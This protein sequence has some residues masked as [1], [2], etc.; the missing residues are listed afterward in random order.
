MAASPEEFLNLSQRLYSSWPVVFTQIPL[1]HRFLWLDLANPDMIM[2]LLTGASMWVQQK[3]M[4][5]TTQDP[6]Q[7]AQSEMMQWMMPMMFGFFTISFSSGLALYWLVSNIISIVIQ[8]FVTGWGSLTWFTKGKDS[9]GVISDGQASAEEAEEEQEER[10]RVLHSRGARSDYEA[11]TPE[12]VRKFLRSPQSVGP[13]SVE[14][15]LQL[16]FLLRA[17]DPGFVYFL[18]ARGRGTFLRGAPIDVSDIVRDLLFDKMKTTVLTSATLAVDGSFEY[19]K[20]RLGIGKAREVRLASEFDYV[21]QAILYLP[22]RMPDPRSREF[23]RAAAQQVVEIVRR[24]RG[25]AFGL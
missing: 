9:S 14:Q 16:G 13:V 10:D 12:D 18:E 4:T 15:L 2:A 7:R 11:G 21:Q 24:S 20:G 23:G 8:Y 19:I 25:R 22:P 17:D 3:M 6:Q 5:P 1:A